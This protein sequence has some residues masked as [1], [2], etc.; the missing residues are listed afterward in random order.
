MSQVGQ[1]CASNI[2]ISFFLPL[3]FV[4]THRT[5]FLSYCFVFPHTFRFSLP[6]LSSF[7]VGPSY[8]DIDLLSLG[9]LRTITVWYQPV[10]CFVYFPELHCGDHISFGF[11][12][13]GLFLHVLSS[14]LTA[15][16]PV[17][18]VFSIVLLGLQVRVLQYRWVHAL[19]ICSSS[20]PISSSFLRPF[21][22]D[23]FSFKSSFLSTPLVFYL[24]SPSC[25]QL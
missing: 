4:A 21:V 6:L 25:P 20:R 18:L 1:W 13:P 14:L 17:S 19:L 2:C 8:T 15:G 7:S 10:S 11:R 24:S 5:C 3:N 22:R 9:D 16:L 23:N 12:F